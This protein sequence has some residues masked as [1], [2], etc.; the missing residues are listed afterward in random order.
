MWSSWTEQLGVFYHKKDYPFHLSCCC[1]WILN[2]RWRRCCRRKEMVKWHHYIQSRS[3]NWNILLFESSLCDIFQFN[4]NELKRDLACRIG[5]VFLRRFGRRSINIYKSMSSYNLVSFIAALNATICI[6]GC[7]KTC[8]KS[9]FYQWWQSNT[10]ELL[11]NVP[12]W[13]KFLSVST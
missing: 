11:L 8:N 1:W 2:E 9:M 4:G 6:F 13:S 10:T 7:S 12:T 5:C 3:D